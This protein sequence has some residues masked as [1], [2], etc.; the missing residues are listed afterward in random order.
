MPFI[1]HLLAARRASLGPLRADNPCLVE[2]EARKKARKGLTHQTPKPGVAE[3]AKQ[4][5]VE[6]G[7]L[8]PPVD[9]LQSAVGWGSSS[10]KKLLP[11]FFFFSPLTGPGTGV[12]CRIELSLSCY[13]ALEEPLPS[14]PSHLSFSIC[15]ISCGGCS[16]EGPDSM[17]QKAIRLQILCKRQYN[18]HCKL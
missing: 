8:T 18:C 13:T 7:N 5:D 17:E 3:G 10:T 15:K 11:F 16:A 12:V 2:E 9:L 6:N 14:G 4:P 1:E